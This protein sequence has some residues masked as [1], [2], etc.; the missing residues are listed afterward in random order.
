MWW[1]LNALPILNVSA[2]AATMIKIM[3]RR[4]SASHQLRGVI[5]DKKMSGSPWLSL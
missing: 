2:T 5:K 4:E 1:V 3:M